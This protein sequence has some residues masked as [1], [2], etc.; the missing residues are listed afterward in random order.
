MKIFNVVP[1][2]NPRYNGFFTERSTAALERVGEYRRN[3]YDR[4][5]TI[6]EITEMAADA[7]VLI[8]G[9]AT[10]M[11]TLDAAKKMPN[12]KL[13][14][15][16]A[17][18]VAPFVAPEIYEQTDIRVICGNDVF[19]RSVAEGTL[20]YMLAALRRVEHY[21]NVMRNGGWKEINFQNRGL[22]GKKVGIIGF[23]TISRYVLELIRW[24]KCEVL[25][26]SS[27]LS[28]EEAAKYGG[29]TASLEEIFSTCEVISVH[30]SMTPKTEGMITRELLSMMRPDA[31]LVNTARGKVI[32]EEAMFEMLL[33]GKFFAAL[34]VYAKEPPLQDDPIRKCDHAFL[35]PHMGGPT[36]DMREIVVLEISEDIQ[37]F[38]EGKPLHLE[39]DGAAAQR[40]TR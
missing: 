36:M 17:G 1:Q 29:R 14:A 15:H 27:H 38:I 21:V 22:I 35:M 23:G 39:V 4:N 24:F 18:S 10:P 3:P 40:M 7:D 12:L 9:W 26:Y 32:D 37:N 13:I 20:C 31:L 11:I 30:S 8:T 6:D 25:I 16:S 2:N 33:E 5:L 28:N 19:A 34:D